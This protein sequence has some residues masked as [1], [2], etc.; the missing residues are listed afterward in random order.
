MSSLPKRPASVPPQ[1]TEQILA[2]H[3]TTI[4]AGCWRIAEL[5][6]RCK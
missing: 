5:A 3:G 1:V 4:P 2:L 6:D